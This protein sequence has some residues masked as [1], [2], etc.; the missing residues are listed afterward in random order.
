MYKPSVISFDY[1]TTSLDYWAP[2][3]QLLSTAFAWRQENGQIKTL[4]TEGPDATADMLRRCVNYDIPLVCHNYCFEWSVTR[5][6]FPDIPVRIEYDTM[7]LAQVYDNG[8]DGD[9]PRFGLADVTGRIL[10]EH[11]GHKEPAYKWIRETLD[12]KKGK[13]KQYIKMLP[14]ELL[15]EYNSADAIVTLLLY[16]HFERSFKDYGYDW[17]LDHKLYL[18]LCQHV[19][20]S[21]KRGIKVQRD[22]LE[23]YAGQIRQ[24]IEEIDRKFKE[25][26]SKEISQIEEAKRKEYLQEPKTNRGRETRLRKISEE[27]GHCRFNPKSTK[28]LKEL[29]V[30]TLGI[31]PQFFTPKGSPSLK[32]AH[33]HTYGEGGKM[34]ANRNKRLLVLKQ[35][36]SLL[37][38]SEADG[39]YHIDMK[40]TGTATGR[41]AGGR[42]D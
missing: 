11:A 32:A 5:K 1:E 23:V 42:V 30:D 20:E 17:R 41:A 21:K 24:E 33:L 13:E 27:P 25:T 12:V 19:S 38:L 2:G 16:E 3:F 34:L 31:K 28:Q 29:F 4:V 6:L 18:H 10:P 9:K 37:A 36:E 8:G 14:K 40:V 26:F 35:T 22:Q 7:R 39:R 15:H